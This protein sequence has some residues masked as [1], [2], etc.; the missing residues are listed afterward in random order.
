MVTGRIEQIG[1]SGILFFSKIRSASA[2]AFPP[3]LSARRGEIRRASFPL[4]RSLRRRDVCRST[5]S[6]ISSHRNDRI[7]RREKSRVIPKNDHRGNT[8]YRAHSRASRIDA[9]T[10]SRLIKRAPPPSPPPKR[11]HARRPINELS[12]MH[13]RSKLRATSRNS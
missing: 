13:S 10:E 4:S 3:L 9:V 2:K 5:L 1:R 11:A 6:P 7:K 12:E 8:I